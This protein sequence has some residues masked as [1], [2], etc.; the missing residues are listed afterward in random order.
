MLNEL[1]KCMPRLQGNG[2]DIPK[3]HKQLHVAFNILLFGSHK[4]IHTGPTEHNH[5]ELSKKTAQGTQMQNAT[6]DWQVANQL[7]DK[8]IVNLELEHIMVVENTPS[9]N[10]HPSTGPY[11]YPCKTSF[12]TC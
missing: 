7:I 1:V 9:L 3:M 2:W 8:M 4:N 11:P 5:I 10:T 6:F 12:L